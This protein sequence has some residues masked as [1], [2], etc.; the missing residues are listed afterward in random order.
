MNYREREEELFD[1]WKSR[2]KALGH[3]NSLA[4]DGLL[5]R[6]DLWIAR[7]KHILHCSGNETELWNTAPLRLAILTKD[8]NDED[9]PWDVRE[10]TGRREG[11]GLEEMCTCPYFYP[12]L[13]RWVFGLLNAKDGHA[14]DYSNVDNPIMIQQ[15]YESAPI[16]RVNCKK[17]CGNSN[18]SDSVFC[19]VSQHCY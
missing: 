12:N 3:D 16:V 14:A 18:I 7:G 1:R 13:Q 15:F 19:F 9:G 10:E 4:K 5:Y 6:G 11:N 2:A 8:I 17:Q